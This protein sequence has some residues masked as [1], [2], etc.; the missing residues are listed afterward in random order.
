MVVNVKPLADSRADGPPIR[1]ADAEGINGSACR[2]YWER[3]S[4]FSLTP[5]CYPELHSRTS[6]PF[7]FPWIFLKT[8]QINFTSHFAHSPNIGRTLGLFGPIDGEDYVVDD[9]VKGL[10]RRV[11]VDVVVLG[12]VKLAAS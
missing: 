11:G 2:R 9:T 4:A 7:T 5:C 10:A 1:D 12:C 8:R 3:L 6:S